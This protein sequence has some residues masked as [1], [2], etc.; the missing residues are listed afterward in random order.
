MKKTEQIEV[1]R[2]E[3]SPNKWP[4]KSVSDAI[5]KLIGTLCNARHAW[6]Q[7]CCE[8]LSDGER[9]RVDMR[10]YPD[11][12]CDMVLDGRVLARWRWEICGAELVKGGL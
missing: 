8:A 5:Q 10:E 2:C 11:G 3:E 9:S 6:G 12:S 7:A 1:L 4:D